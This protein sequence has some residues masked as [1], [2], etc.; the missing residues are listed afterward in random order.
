MTYCLDER[1]SWA[2]YLSLWWF[3]GWVSDL[4]ILGYFYSDSDIKHLKIK[5]FFPPSEKKNLI[6]NFIS[7]LFWSPLLQGSFEDYSLPLKIHVSQVIWTMTFSNSFILNIIHLIL[8]ATLEIVINNN[9]ASFILAA[10]ETSTFSVC[11]LYS[12]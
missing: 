10:L 11:I 9:N 12:V 7:L 5:S 4:D 6:I 8:I 1:G 2:L 3:G